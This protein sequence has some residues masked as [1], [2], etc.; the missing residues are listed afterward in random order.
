MK[1]LLFLLMFVFAVWRLFSGPGSVSLGPGVM[2]GAVPY[3]ETVDAP[4]SR[5]IDDYTVTDLATFR[6]KAKVLARK[7]Y[8]IGRESD[9]SPVDLALG[10]G[11][12]SDESVLDEIEIS[13]SGRFYRWQVESFPIP[14]REI[15][16]HSANMHLIPATDRIRDEIEK[17]REGEVIEISGSLV[18]VTSSEDGWRWRSSLTRDDTGAGACELILVDSFI[19]VSL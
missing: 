14:R 9:L 1:K 15:E 2:A 16:T 8:N 11:N 5:R 18:H 13:Q 7:D 4:V 6:I 12:M 17:V 19:I 10:W 3:Q